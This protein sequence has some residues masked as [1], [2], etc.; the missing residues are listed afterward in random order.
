[1]EEQVYYSPIQERMKRMAE[2]VQIVTGLELEGTRLEV[3]VAN[4]DQYS[5][6]EYI[7]LRRQ[8]F[9]ASDSSVLLG[10]NP[11]KT[12]P[13]L[14]KEKASNVITA[15]ERAVGEKAAVRKGR[16]LEPLIIHKFQTAFKQNCIKP[17]DMYKIT[18]TNCLNVNFDG[19]TGE[20]GRYVPAEIKVVTMYGEKHY[21][22]LKAIYDE[23]NGFMPLPEN[24]SDSNNT[25][26]T[27]AA[28]YGIPP[29]YYTQLQQQMLGLNADYGYL[30]VLFDRDWR[31]RTFFVYRDNKMIEELIQKSDY[32]WQQVLAL[33]NKV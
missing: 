17:K 4:I 1:M 10:V 27:K 14:I 6:D 30:S 12:I 13:E 2:N 20:P 7:M 32:Y 31:M 19:V 15:E 33:K 3:A 24:I 26:E 11:Y 18:G 22:P 16:D 23:V 25:L 8:G 5:N 9:G 29:Y 21:N 28:H